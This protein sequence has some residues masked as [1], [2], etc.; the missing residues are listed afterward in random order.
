MPEKILSICIPTF[1]RSNILDKTLSE[2]VLEPSFQLGKIE[3]C[4][5]DNASTDNTEEVVKKYIN[6]YKNIIYNRNKINTVVIDGNF[7]IVGAMAS[8]SFIKFQNDHAI[9]IPTE[10]DKI[11]EFIE[12]SKKEKPILF[13]SNNALLDKTNKIIH[14]DSLDSF[15]K[16]ASYRTTWVGGAGIWRDDFIAL[17][18][19]DRSV[20]KF[21]WCPDIYLRLLSSG[22][23]AIIYNRQ[24]FTMQLLSKKGGY[25]L[26]QIF[27]TNYLSLYLPYIK[28]GKLS[29]N[30]FRKEK[31][32]LYR[33]YLIPTASL[34]ITSTST[35]YS[36]ETDGALKILFKYYW[37]FPYFYFG[38][39]R[40]IILLIV[41][42]PFIQKIIF[43][44]KLKHLKNN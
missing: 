27:V 26:F 2:L 24:I 38:L 30:V 40:F 14:C 36:F 4:I 35:K 19:R 3:I 9:F 5:S 10:L 28:S 6:K 15:V 18:D 29:A 17:K 32:R 23:K 7:P 12:S 1:N 8:G 44:L 34:Y 43:N 16:K 13:F 22:R 31:I 21:M 41:Y 33:D 39:I 11:I 20:E 42:N 37:N 25:N